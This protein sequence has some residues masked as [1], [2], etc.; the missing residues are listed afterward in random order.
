MWIVVA[1][2]TAEGPG[3]ASGAFS[4]GPSLNTLSLLLRESV[5]MILMFLSTGL[6]GKHFGGIGDREPQDNREPKFPPNKLE[7]LK[8]QFM[9]GLKTLQN[10]SFTLLWAEPPRDT[11]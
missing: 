9:V 10:I 7:H 2:V 11:G 3:E 1:V 5:T 6:H 8:R 4:R